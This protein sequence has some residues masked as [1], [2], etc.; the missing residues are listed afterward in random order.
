M[1]HDLFHHTA[2]HVDGNRKPNS[3]ASTAASGEL[4]ARHAEMIQRLEA[5]VMGPEAMEKAEQ[6]LALV[7]KA[8]GVEVNGNYFFPE[9]QKAVVPRLSQSRLPMCG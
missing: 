2:R 1:V 4:Q 6:N 3:L 5:R 8:L 9:D 7:V